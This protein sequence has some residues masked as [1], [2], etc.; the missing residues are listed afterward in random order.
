MVWLYEDVVQ[1]AMKTSNIVGV[2]WLAIGAQQGREGRD[3]LH[4][5]GLLRPRAAPVWMLLR[6]DRL[7]DQLKHT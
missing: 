5:A 7:T 1:A 2:G 4:T 6:D 3:Q